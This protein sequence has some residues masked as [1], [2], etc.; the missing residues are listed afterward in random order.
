MFCCAHTF[1]SRQEALSASS[2]DS[3]E[4]D[5]FTPDWSE[6]RCWDPQE[7]S[8]ER[9]A[10]ETAGSLFTSIFQNTPLP[11]GYPQH[12]RSF[13]LSTPARA[14]AD[15]ARQDLSPGLVD[16]EFPLGSFRAQKNNAVSSTNST[17]HANRVRGSSHLHL[18]LRLSEFTGK[19]PKCRARRREYLEI[20]TFQISFIVPSP[21][22]LSSQTLLSQQLSLTSLLSSL[23]RTINYSKPFANASKTLTMRDGMDEPTLRVQNV[24]QLRH[25]ERNAA[26]INSRAPRRHWRPNCPYPTAAAS[27]ASDHFACAPLYAPMACLLAVYLPPIRSE[28]GEM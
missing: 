22:D 28:L 5:V 2:G 7:W 10:A 3:P 24:R 23:S 21:I 14:I 19:G 17:G 8:C 26:P 1:G 16:F 20:D 25:A 6:S 9:P 11:I 18:W 13:G 4:S 12:T 15:S 27:L